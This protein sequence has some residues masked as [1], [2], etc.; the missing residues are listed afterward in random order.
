MESEVAERERLES[1]RKA[2][3][4]AVVT[5]GKNGAS[6]ADVMGDNIQVVWPGSR[7]DA[8]QKMAQ[9]A[10]D[11]LVEEGY[12]SKK[13]GSYVWHEA[14]N[15]AMGQPK[16]TTGPPGGVAKKRKA[17]ESAAGAVAAAA[18]APRINAADAAGVQ[19]LPAVREPEVLPQEAEELPVPLACICLGCSAVWND[20]LNLNVA[21]AWTGC[22]E[23]DRWFCQTCAPG[24]HGLLTEH[25]KAS[26]HV[27][28]GQVALRPALARKQRDVP[29][30]VARARALASISVGA[31]EVLAD[32]GVFIYGGKV[33][34]NDAEVARY[35]RELEEQMQH[36]STRGRGGLGLLGY[37]GWTKTSGPQF[38]CATC[39]ASRSLPAGL[40]E[41]AA[42]T[43]Q[44]FCASVGQAC[45]AAAAAAVSMPNR[46]LAASPAAIVD[47]TGA[48]PLQCTGGKK[49]GKGA[50][51][52][53][54]EAQQ[55]TIN[56]LSSN[57]K[58][59]DYLRIE[60]NDFK[61][62]F[63][64][65][66][67]IGKVYDKLCKSYI[68]ANHL[69]EHVMTPKHKNA[70]M[71]QKNKKVCDQRIST[72]LRTNGATDSDTKTSTKVFRVKF[73]QTWM[74]MGLPLRKM[75]GLA[76]FLF[77][78]MTNQE[79]LPSRSHLSREYIPLIHDMEVAKMMD[80]IRGKPV[81]VI[82]DGTTDV[83]ENFAIGVRYHHTSSSSSTSGQRTF[84][85]QRLL[86]L[87]RYEHSMDSE[88]LIATLL[89]TLTSPIL[90]AE[91]RVAQS[92]RGGFGMNRL[93]IV[94]MIHD[95][96]SVNEKAMG[97]TGT[98][99]LL[100]SMLPAYV[101]VGCVS[102]TATNTAHVV[103]RGCV[104]ATIFFQTL[105]GVFSRST[106][107]RAS[108]KK[109][110]NTRWIS[111]S[112][113]R[114]FG[115]RDAM[116]QAYGRL[117]LI[118]DW[119]E[120]SADEFI[121]STES[122]NYYK[123]RD[124]CVESAWPKPEPGDRT[125]LEDFYPYVQRRLQWRFVRLEMALLID[126]T[127]ALRRLTYMAEGDYSAA[128]TVFDEILSAKA[129][130]EINVAG[131]ESMSLVNAV[132]VEWLESVPMGQ[133]R[134]EKRQELTLYCQTRMQPMVN[135]F[136]SHFWDDDAKL[137][138]LVRTYE[139]ARICNPAFV[140][141]KGQTFDIAYIT[142]FLDWLQDGMKSTT[143]VVVRDDV[144]IESSPSQQKFWRAD[145]VGLMA[146]LP[147]YKQHCAN[148]DIAAYN[149]LD[150]KEKCRMLD[151]FWSY[152]YAE[153]TAWTKLARNFQLLQPSSAFVE[154]IFSQLKLILDRGGMEGAL[155]DLIEGSLMLV[156]NG[157]EES[158]WA[159]DED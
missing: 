29:P 30:E 139:A 91:Q 122:S 43:I 47:L 39:S 80:E 84:P 68:S 152:D 26:G 59:L 48:G 2:V 129:S 127:A 114:W 65:D 158:Q 4:A 120:G 11:W 104:E 121:A 46:A 119:L 71:A 137:K 10:L 61:G 51:T 153:F 124:I 148:F 159:E 14:K 16:G 90:N 41:A 87:G 88:Q 109:F 75:D 33:I 123:L 7:V 130:I 44:M 98:S 17:Q 111:W 101:D 81:A 55:S 115:E 15:R 1:V 154:R 146:Q 135:Y 138:K 78:E 37:K 38:R 5:R 67:N 35:T 77:E 142:P 23:C 144:L 24:G 13:T 18:P 72:Y 28:G 150:Y 3:Y 96:A 74:A 97:S 70:L 128:F 86:R 8:T 116:E 9:T 53:S 105:G 108:Y 32:A 118:Q 58:I 42:K 25:I 36:S 93:H 107:A 82:F 49:G 103:Q 66:G 149:A 94:A 134:A 106:K 157:K 143:G 95:C 21:T 34:T 50:T 126:S 136:Y 76:N 27:Q 140:H 40:P 56:S 117:S 92:S 83:C 131:V 133:P 112:R 73:V 99:F 151:A 6:I 156:V 12:I 54:A 52:T 79:K 141:T 64:T 100:P 102:H 69:N 89:D 45:E 155:L 145:R 113:T 31:Q 147:A 63:E 85:V 62:H 19:Q 132:I 57:R 22:D 125:A 60:A 110:V 20:D